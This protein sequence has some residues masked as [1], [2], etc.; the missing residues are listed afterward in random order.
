[1]SELKAFDLGRLAGFLKLQLFKFRK[2]IVLTLAV[3]FGML[4][5]VGLLLDI[6]VD[7]TK[8]TFEHMENFTGS[9][10]LGGFV[11]SSM[12][13]NEL[14]NKLKAQH[15]L[16]VPVSALEKFIAMWLLTGLGWA[17][18]YTLVFTLYT[19]V[20][21]VVGPVLFSYVSFRAFDPLGAET[22][23]RIVVY[24]VLQGVFLIGSVRFKS[25]ALPKTL[26]A[27]LLVALVCGS[28]AFMIMKETFLTEH[29]CGN[30]EC[31]YITEMGKHPIW[32]VVKWMFWSVL[33]PVTWL[34]TYLGLKEQEV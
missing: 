20:A 30:G 22:L 5:F 27:I 19:W 9:I 23:L 26:L 15:Y 21:N 7:P 8:V 31:E 17:V 10:L 29:R 6:Y 28:C 3:T 24:L 25:Y 2:G 13:F 14:G 12:A 1:M 33:G 32:S 4:F 16:M 34:V 18:G 11:L